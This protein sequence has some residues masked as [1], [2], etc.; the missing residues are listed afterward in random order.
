M[1][2]YGNLETGVNNAYT[3]ASNL[4]NAG[5]A[6]ATAGYKL[7]QDIYEL[8]DDYVSPY[9]ARNERIDGMLECRDRKELQISAPARLVFGEPHFYSLVTPG[10]FPELNADS[11]NDRKR[12]QLY[13]IPAY[14]AGYP[15][16]YIRSVPMLTE[17]DTEVPILPWVS[18][19]ALMDLTRAAIEADKKN[20]T[21]MA[22]YTSAA[23]L[24]V[25]KMLLAD[26]KSRGPQKL[27]MASQYTRHRLARVTRYGGGPRLP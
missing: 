18:T 23:E 6:T 10:P 17:G 7:Y 13:P 20:Y 24:E 26:A 25:S 27:R 21:G 2:L 1:V 16:T 22:A 5:L 15:Y 3:G 8:P 4:G 9:S 11:E 19:K 12:A 14:A